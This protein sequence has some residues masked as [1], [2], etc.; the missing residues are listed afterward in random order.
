MSQLYIYVCVSD[1]KDMIES[2]LKLNSCRKESCENKR[3][4][5]R[6]HCNCKTPN[7]TTPIFIFYINFMTPPLVQASEYIVIKS[8][9]FLSIMYTYIVVIVIFNSLIILHTRL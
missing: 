6:R 2:Y 1:I 7:C 9:L 5:L 4:L 3:I 8:F